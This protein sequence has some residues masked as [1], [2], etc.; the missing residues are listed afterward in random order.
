[1]EEVEGGKLAAAVKD[2][3]P[4]YVRAWSLDAK[5]PDNRGPGGCGGGLYVC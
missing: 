4:P 2:N 5:G 3:S 1:M